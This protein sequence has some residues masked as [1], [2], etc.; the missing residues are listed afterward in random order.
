MPLVTVLIPRLSEEKTIGAVIKSLLDAYAK[1]NSEILA[2]DGGSSVLVL[3]TRNAS[4]SFKGH[5]NR[6]VMA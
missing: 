6:I 2:S 3:D 1:E 5:G 4:K